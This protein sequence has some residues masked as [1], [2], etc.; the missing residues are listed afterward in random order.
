MIQK[1]DIT[2]IIGMIKINYEKAYTF[3]STQDFSLLIDFWYDSL[4]EYPKEIVFEATKKAIQ[5]SEFAPK[6]STILTEIKKLTVSNELS[7]AEL[8]HSLE[9]EF[10]GVWD[11]CQDLKYNKDYDTYETKLNAIWDRLPNV[12]K[13][14]LGNK[15]TLKQLAYTYM[16]EGSREQMSFEKTRFL[17]AIPTLKDRLNSK[18]FLTDNNLLIGEV[19]QDL[20]ENKKD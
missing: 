7:E 10:Y 11:I 4:K 15:G 3:E 18:K 19:Q 17:K 6:I 2:K 12:V 13:E 5:N 20:I 16:C 9:K 1:S 8:W 14:W